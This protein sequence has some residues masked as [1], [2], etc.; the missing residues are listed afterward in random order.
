MTLKR[1]VISLDISNTA[2]VLCQDGSRRQRLNGHLTE[3]SRGDRLL[4]GFG[5]CVEVFAQT[6]ADACLVVGVVARGGGNVGMPQK[7]A[8]GV[9]ALFGRDQGAEFLPQFV[10]RFV[11]GDAL[12]PQPGVEPLERFFAAVIGSG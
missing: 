12:A 9:N 4:N 5:R 2:S 7:T 6:D 8:G 3:A 1:R 10:E 11:G